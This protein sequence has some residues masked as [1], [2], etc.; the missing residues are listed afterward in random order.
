MPRK[1]SKLQKS[2]RKNK[3]RRKPL[4]LIPLP[5]DS[6]IPLGTEIKPLPENSFIPFDASIQSLPGTEF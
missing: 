6:F 5:E 3:S 4:D 2:L 1:A